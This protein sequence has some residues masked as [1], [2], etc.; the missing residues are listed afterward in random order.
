VRRRETGVCRVAV[1]DEVVA[2][3]ATQ[4]CGRPARRREERLE[5]VDGCLGRV[6]WSID[7]EVVVE[8]TAVAAG[9]HR[10]D[11]HDV[12]LLHSLRRCLRSRHL[13]IDH[14]SR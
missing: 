8:F 6:T 10:V 14:R 7:G 13:V 4:I 1:V 9:R 2:D 3:Y 5:A 12:A 11:V